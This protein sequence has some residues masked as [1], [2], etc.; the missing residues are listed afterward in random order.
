MEK[1]TN[2]ELAAHGY[3][4]LQA[5]PYDP[6]GN[7][8]FKMGGNIFKLR[9]QDSKG[10]A[11]FWN[12]AHVRSYLNCEEELQMRTMRTYK[13]YLAQRSS[14]SSFG[15]GTSFETEVSAF[16]FSVGASASHSQSTSQEESNIKHVFEEEQGEIVM[17]KTTCLTH[18]LA[19]NTRYYRPVFSRGFVNA[20]Y[21]LEKAL[22]QP[23][24][25]KVEAYKE[26][27]LT[28]GTHY[29][30]RTKFGASMT[31]QRVFHSRSSSEEESN[32]RSDDFRTAASACLSAGG[33]Y[34]GVSASGKIC[35]NTNSSS[36]S[37]SSNS[38]STGDAMSSS[39]LRI[40]SRGSRPTE[41]TEAWASSEYV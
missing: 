13:D 36:S 29:L 26:F 15:F 12:F 10:S 2:F 24:P 33:S 1:D 17:A 38:S 30:S 32:S 5:N 27:V 7:P 8:G 28:Y 11:G 3:D 4:L 35:A 34:A 21:T 37:S 40:I 20:L 19:Y 6:K 9:C 41:N 23:E 25:I 39:D 14:A 22:G 31:Y 18:D 16:G